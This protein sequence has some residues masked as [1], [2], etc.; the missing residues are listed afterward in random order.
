MIKGPFLKNQH[1]GI[2]LLAFFGI[3][4]VSFVLFYQLAYQLIQFYFGIDISNETALDDLTDE[5]VLAAGK[6]LAFIIQIGFF[7]LPCLV[8]SKLMASREDNFLRTQ[9][10][11]DIRNMAII[12]LIA[13]FAIPLINVIH[14]FNAQIDFS[15][16][17][18]VT[19]K[20]NFQDAAMFT[21]IPSGVL[22]NIL[23]F[24]V[25]PALVE[26]LFFRS[27]LLRFF[28]RSSKNVHLAVITGGL[29]FAFMHFRPDQFFPIAAMG[30]LYG[31]IFFRT[32][33]IWYSVVAHFIN[34][35]STIVF[36]Y[37]TV[38]GHADESILEYG[39]G[40]NE[41]IPSV[42]SFLLLTGSLILLFK[43]ADGSEMKN[44]FY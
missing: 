36:Y 24:A 37:L 13:V 35:F 3:M 44:T 17:V 26:E 23:I 30:I 27:I 9:G 39:T 8:F 18:D 14:Y 42:I 1:P 40:E 33:N 21:D 19:D 38:T 34:N 20:K 7:L 11:I 32:G 2:Q 28:Y 6:L 4:L 22:S 16:F 29:I 15:S 12:F 5:N 43:R 10:K 25:M 41:T 31:Y